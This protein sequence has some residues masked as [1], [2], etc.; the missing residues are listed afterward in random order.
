MGTGFLIFIS[1]FSLSHGNFLF[2]PACL[3]TNAHFLK[4][5][6]INS[7][8]HD[9]SLILSVSVFPLGYFLM[10]Q[11]NH[12]LNYLAA[13]FVVSHC[14]DLRVWEWSELYVSV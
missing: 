5:F 6:I 8:C 1:K 4:E 3:P 14:V 7:C 2:I 10:K 13:G 12:W 11:L 9:L